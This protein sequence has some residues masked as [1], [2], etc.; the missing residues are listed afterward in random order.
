MRANL[1]PKGKK[2]AQNTKK[3]KEKP[4]RVMQREAPVMQMH[5]TSANRIPCNCNYWTRRSVLGE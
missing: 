5:L 1:E 3:R 4:T 2:N